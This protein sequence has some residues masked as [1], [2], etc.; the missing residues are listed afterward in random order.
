MKSDPAAL[1]GVMPALPPLP[2]PAAN[3]SWWQQIAFDACRIDL[4][5]EHAKL[6]ERGRELVLPLFTAEQ[7]RTYAASCV[8]AEREAGAERCEQIAAHDLSMQTPR[9]VAER[10]A[11]AI[12]AR[13]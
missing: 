3:A 1:D 13:T 8:L 10:C 2:E 7:M 4:L 5:K 9:Q 12:R 6:S 11:A